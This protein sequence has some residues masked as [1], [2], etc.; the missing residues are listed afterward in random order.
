MVFL[1]LTIT[2]Q[3]KRLK[4]FFV[5]LG[6]SADCLQSLTSLV[7]DSL[8]RSHWPE[9]FDGGFDGQHF[10]FLSNM[11]QILCTQCS[12]PAEVMLKFP[13]KPRKY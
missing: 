9:M 10:L 6:F 3:L 4:L 2:S 11:A 7:K 1:T 5:L 12:G 13:A 8:K